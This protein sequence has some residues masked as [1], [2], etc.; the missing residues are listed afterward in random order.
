[1]KF[2]EMLETFSLVPSVCAYIRD[3]FID[4]FSSTIWPNLSNSPIYNISGISTVWL[5]YL[6]LCDLLYTY[7][8]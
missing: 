3:S 7:L 5:F 4:R 8:Q 2:E 6:C 1:M